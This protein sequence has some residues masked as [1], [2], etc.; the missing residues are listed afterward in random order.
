VTQLGA[1]YKRIE[2]RDFEPDGQLIGLLPDTNKALVEYSSFYLNLRYDTRD[3]YINPSKGFVLQSDLE[4]APKISF[5]SVDFYQWSFWFQYYTVVL[6]PKT[7]FATRLGIARINGENLPFQLL[8]PVGG[9]RTLRGFPQ[10]RFLDK[11]ASILNLEIRFHIWQ[12]LGGLI[13]ADFG[14][15]WPAIKNM[16]LQNWNNNLVLGLRYYMD[17]YVVRVDVGL[18]RETFGIYFNFGHIF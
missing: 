10:D 9:N 5:N 12:R 7:I 3:S 6:A 13:G 14:K 1:K 17:T 15:V 18:S 11:V 8:L 2:S 16:D 4:W